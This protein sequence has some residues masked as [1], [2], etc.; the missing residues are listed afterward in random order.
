MVA[1]TIPLLGTS[2]SSIFSKQRTPRTPHVGVLKWRH[3]VEDRPGRVSSEESRRNTMSIMDRKEFC[4]RLLVFV[5]FFVVFGVVLVW[6]R[7][8][9]T[10]SLRSESGVG[11]A[12][13]APRRV[14]QEED[15]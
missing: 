3:T 4:R 11:V 9:C 8:S 6:L 7:S 5:V 2:Q 1:S 15:V 14:P 13:Q 12:H 10:A